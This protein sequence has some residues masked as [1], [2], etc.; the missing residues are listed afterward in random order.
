MERKVLDMVDAITRT[1]NS[2]YGHITWTTLSEMN[3]RTAAVVDRTTDVADRIMAF[4]TCL[5]VLEEHITA[6]Q[7]P[8]TA[9]PPP[10]VNALPAAP[11]CQPLTAA[12]AR[13]FV[14]LYNEIKGNPWLIV[15]WHE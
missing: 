1:V 11:P 2:S 4:T 12:A 7:N 3:N 8:L 5:D 6:H 14:P 9:Q 15:L 10:K 13:I